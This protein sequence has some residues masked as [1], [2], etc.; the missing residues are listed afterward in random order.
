MTEKTSQVADAFSDAS[1]K[2]TRRFN[3]VNRRSLLGEGKN[4]V[5]RFTA[6]QISLN[7]KTSQVADAL[8]ALTYKAT[9]RFNKLTR[10]LLKEGDMNA[11]AAKVAQTQYDLNAENAARYAAQVNRTVGEGLN[12]RKHASC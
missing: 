10:H 3:H 12:A 2:A 7:E 1:Y 5:D 11:A 9:G 6:S 8:A 4:Y